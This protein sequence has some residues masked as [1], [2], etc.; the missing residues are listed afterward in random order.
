MKS[1]CLIFLITMTNAFA[2]EMSYQVP[3]AEELK[4]F[5]DFKITGKTTINA[6]GLRVIDYK[7]PEELTGSGY[8]S[9]VLTEKR[10][11]SLDTIFK[12]DL[13]KALCK[14]EQGELNCHVEYEDLNIDM[15]AVESFINTKF[16]DPTERM[17]RLEVAKIF[18]GE[19]VGILLIKP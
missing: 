3:V 11:H 12:G 6:Q 16:Q 4:S 1:I 5:A 19:P 13:G 10:V 15:T 2:L 17:N 9:I 18:S 14:E 8:G 7:L